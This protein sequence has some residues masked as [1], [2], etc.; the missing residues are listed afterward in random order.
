MLGYDAP[1]LGDVFIELQARLRLPQQSSECGL[2]LLDRVAPQVRP[3]EVDDRRR[4]SSLR[5]A[6]I[7]VFDRLRRHDGLVVL[8]AFDLPQ[9]DQHAAPDAERRRT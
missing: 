3:V 8:F 2:A 9:S 7:P 4:G 5:R 1:Q 6:G